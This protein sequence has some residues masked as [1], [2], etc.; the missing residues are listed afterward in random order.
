MPQFAWSWT[1]SA[2]TTFS[3][4][5]Q[6]RN[7]AFSAAT[8]SRTWSVSLRRRRET[9]CTTRRAANG[10]PARAICGGARLG[11]GI[12]SGAVPTSGVAIGC[13]ICRRVS[14]EGLRRSNR[15]RFS[16]CA[17]RSGDGGSGAQ[18]EDLAVRAHRPEHEHL[19]R[20]PGDPPRREV[21]NGHDLPAHEGLAVRVRDRQL[22]RADALPDL[23]A[24]VD[25]QAV[26][27]LARL[28][29]R[30]GRDDPPDAHLDP[31]EL[32]DVDH[33]RRVP[34]R[35]GTGAAMHW[36]L[37]GTIEPVGRADAGRVRFAGRAAGACPGGLVRQ[38]TM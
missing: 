31:L 27:R 3:A 11:S 37:G 14:G 9:K 28:G 17:A 26:G 21:E 35:G 6:S 38:E 15:R 24:E 1:S 5:Y 12:P 36:A 16:R 33:R 2:S 34:E 4:K 30:L 8:T 7:S 25:P 23:R 32:L 18:E 20:E 29:E 22:G 13:V 19:A 10:S